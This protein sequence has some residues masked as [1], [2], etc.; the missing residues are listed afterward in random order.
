MTKFYIAGPM[1]GLPDYNRP[2]FLLAEIA[3]SAEGHTVLNPANHIPMVNPDSIDHAQ[4]MQ[5]ALAML[6]ACDAVYFLDGWEKSR[7][8]RME[9]DYARAKHKKTRYGVI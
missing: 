3:L 1:T 7:G 6:D 2:A 9:Y 8:A 5:I 4:Y